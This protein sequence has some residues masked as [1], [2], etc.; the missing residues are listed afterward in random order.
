MAQPE[1]LRSYHFVVEIEGITQAT[2]AEAILPAAWAEVIEYREGSSLHAR[3]LPGRIHYANVVLR[4]GLTTSHELYD[5]WRT[6][7]T[8]AVQRRQVAITL[9]ADD[10]S[11]S[12]RW[13]VRNAWPAKL[14]PVTLNADSPDVAI[15]TLELANEGIELSE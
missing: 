8:G 14:G 4:W 7:E 12:Q 5:W 2:F 10:G 6:V 13:I 3:K 15:E 9:L 11:E 1:P